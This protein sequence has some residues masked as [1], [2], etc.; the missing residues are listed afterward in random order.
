MLA[1]DIDPKEHRDEISR[2]NEAAQNNTLQHIASQWLEIKKS[3]VSLNHA[4][5]IWRSLELHL[6]P[7]LGKVPI[8]K[9]TAVKAIDTIQRVAAKGCLDTVKRLCQ[10][11]NEIMVYAV[12]SGIITNNPLSEIKQ[13]FLT[14]EKQHLPTLKPEQLPTLMAGIIYSQYQNNDSLPY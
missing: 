11:L 5:D 13:T 1:K 10:R 4:D 2:L 12:N 9:I 3:K 7:N 14:P 8:H 6:F